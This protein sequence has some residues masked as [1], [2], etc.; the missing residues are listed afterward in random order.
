MKFIHLRRPGSA[1]LDMTVGSPVSLIA[2][3]SLPLIAGNLFQQLYSIADAAIIGKFVGVD[4]F[5]AVSCASWIIWL[6]NAASRDISNAF[7]IAASIRVGNKNQA[8]LRKIVATTYLSGAAL[9]AAIVSILLLGMNTILKLLSVPDSILPQARI[10]LSF[11]VL[12]MPFGMTYHL[13]SALLRA[14]GNSDVSFFAVTVSTITNIFLDLLFVVIFHWSVVGAAVATLIAQCAAM[15]IVLAGARKNEI[16]RLPRKDLK[17]DGKILA[18]VF[19]LWTPMMVNSLVISLGGMYVQKAVNAIGSYFTAGV[20][21]SS[22]LFNLLEAVIMAIQAGTSVFVGQNLGAGQAVR[23]R[24]GL[25]RILLVS[26]C[27]TVVMAALVGLFADPLV[28]FFLSKKDAAIYAQAHSVGVRSTRV[29][30]YGMLIMTPMYLYRS[31]LQTIGHPNYAMAAGF[32]QVAARAL[33]VYLLPPLIGEYAYYFP[34][35][36]AWVVTL[37][38]VVIPFYFYI[39]R[40]CRKER[41]RHTLSL[42]DPAPI[43]KQSLPLP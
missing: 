27:L 34:T 2:R 41:E 37:P 5:A 38:V 30:L 21:S 12:A 39:N 40:M 14:V 32:L 18:E 19:K 11:L 4:A 1:F 3:F 31:S 20:E 9:C 17:A 22:V 16:F 15:L 6:I 33:T 8:D 13:T 10:Y 29:I 7:C 25:H 23:I 26:F 28:G 42:T 35:V 24:S 36:S 43:A